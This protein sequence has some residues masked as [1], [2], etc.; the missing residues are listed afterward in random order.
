MDEEEIIDKAKQ[1]EVLEKAGDLNLV[2]VARFAPI[3][4]YHRIKEI[5]DIL[6]QEK[7][8]FKWYICRKR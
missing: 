8:D 1:S 2:T 6:I 7:V 4:G 3:K 5:I